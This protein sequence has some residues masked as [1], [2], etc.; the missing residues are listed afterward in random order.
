[1]R[2]HP[3]SVK[4]TFHVLACIALGCSWVQ[5]TAAAV[6]PSG[7]Y[8][9]S[10]AI[11]TPSFHELVPQ[12]SIEYDSNGGNGMLGVGWSLQGLSKI[13]VTSSTGGTPQNDPSDRFRLDGIELIACANAPVGSSIAKSPSC[14]YALPAPLVGYTGR[15]ETFKRIA[16]EPSANGGRWFVWNRDGSKRTYIQSRDMAQWNIADVIDVHGNRVSYGYIHFGIGASPEYLNEVLYNQT[17]IKLHWE[18]RSDVIGFAANSSKAFVDHRLKSI[19]IKVEGK[20][21]RAYAIQYGTSAGTGRSTPVRV[22]TYGTNATVDADGNV[23]GPS[24]PAVTMLYDD[25]LTPLDW[26]S[27]IS[28]AVNLP[29]ATTVGN[30]PNQYRYDYET[31]DTGVDTSF[32][33]GDFDGDGR[34]D[35]LV[36]SVQEDP[37][38]ARLFGTTITP[39]HAKLVT[40]VR[41]ASQ[42]WVTGDVPFDAPAHWGDISSPPHDGRNKLVKAWVADVNGDGLDDLML[43]G[44]NYL[45]ATNPYAGLQFQLNAAISSGDGTFAL[46]QPQFTPMP[47]TSAVVWGPRNAYP[48]DV[49]IC[50]PG[51]FDG[52]GRADFACMFQDSASKHFLGVA[53]A[54]S[55]GSFS[56]GAVQLIADDPGTEVTGP[57]AGRVPFET[58]RMAAGD[59]NN[60][61]QTDLF[62]LDLNPTDVKACAQ[63]GEPTADAGG[64]VPIRLT[65]TIKY[66]LLT[67]TSTGDGFDLQRTPTP[68]T[69]AD[70]LREVPGS[71]A[72][73]DLDGDGRADVMFM[74]GTV[75]SERFQTLKKIRTAIRDVAGSYN[76]SEVDLAPALATTQVSYALGDVNGDGR[77][78]LMIATPITTGAGMGCSSATFQRAVLTAVAAKKDGSLNLPSR[79][80][81]CTVSQEVTNSWAEWTYFSDLVMLQGGDSNGD[82]YA[83]FILPVVRPL[84]PR[85]SGKALVAVYD[86]VAQPANDAPRRWIGADVNGDGKTD[87]ISIAP[88][89]YDSW[90]TTLIAQ[91][92]GRYRVARFQL[93]SNFSTFPGPFQNASMRSWRIMD[94]NAD[95]K[96]DIVHLQCAFPFLKRAC[97]LEL[98]SFLSLGDGT[99]TREAVSHAAAVASADSTALAGLRIGD[100]NG[101][102]RPDLVQTL[103]LTDSANGA[104]SLA[105]RTLFSSGSGWNQQP[106]QPITVSGAA[107]VGFISPMASLLAWHLGDFDGDGRTDL[108]HIISN[109][110][111]ARLTV[112]SFDD[113]SWKSMSTVVRH[114]SVLGGWPSYKGLSNVVRWRVA[115]VNGDGLSDLVRLVHN[116]TTFVVQSLE[117]LG[118]HTWKDSVDTVFLPSGSTAAGFFGA[119]DFLDVDV[120]GDGLSDFAFFDPDASGSLTATV[121]YASGTGFGRIERRSINNASTRFVPRPTQQ[122]GD[123]TGSGSTSLLYVDQVAGSRSAIAIRSVQLGGVDD[124]LVQHGGSGSVTDVTYVAAGQFIDANASQSCGLPLGSV[125]KVVQSTAT[126]DGRIAAKDKTTYGYNCP[127]WSHYHRTL[128]GWEEV[129]AF[130]PKL[131]NR[132]AFAVRSRYQNSDSC[133]AQLGAQGTYDASDRRFVGPRSIIA[134][135]NPGTEPPYRCLTNYLQRVT[136]GSAQYSTAVNVNTS[137]GYDEFGNVVAEIEDGFNG[138]ARSTERTFNYAPDLFIVGALGSVTLRDGPDSSAQILHSRWFCYDGDNTLTCTTPPSKGLLT[139]VIAWSGQGLGTYPITR[140]Q[141]DALGNLVSVMDPNGHGTAYF[142]DPVQ[143]SFPEAVVNALGQTV[144]QVD[145][146]RTLGM[147]TQITGMNGEKTVIEYDEFGRTKR[148]VTPSN[149]TMT[150][151]YNSWGDPKRQYILDTQHDGSQDGLWTRQYLDGLGRVY[152][153]ERKSDKPNEIL[154]QRFLYSDASSLLYRRSL[155]SRWSKSGPFRA[156]AYT[157]YGYDEAGRLLKL[158]HPGGATIKLGIEASANR[159][160]LTLTDEAGRQ[161]QTYHDAFERLVESRAF[162]G[163]QIASTKYNYDG[164]DQIRKVIDP[165]GNVTLYEWDLLGRNTKVTDPD[166]GIR[167]KSYDLAGNLKTIT[168]DVSNRMLTLNYDALNRVTERIY[169]G[170]RVIWNYDEATSQNGRGRLTSF[171]DLTTTGCGTDSG[172]VIHYEPTGQTRMVVRCIQGNRATFSFKYDPLVGRL[173]ETTYP[174]GEVVTYQYDATGLLSHMPGIIEIQRRDASLRPTRIKYGNGVTRRFEYDVDRGWLRRQTDR[175]ANT[176]IFDSTYTYDSSG[177]L[178]TVL[179]RANNLNWAIRYDGLQRVKSLSG[180]Q[181]QT[182]DYDLAGNIM[183][184][185]S[186]GYY[187]Y[188]A[189]GATACTR[190][191]GAPGPCKQPHAAQSAGKFSLRYDD[192]GLLSSMTDTAT[193][194][195]RSIDWTFDMKPSVVLDFDGTQTNF[196]YD[197]FGNRAVETRGQETIVDFGPLAHK[198]SSNGY[199]NTYIADDR[200]IAIKRGGARTWLHHDRSGSVRALTDANGVVV[201]RLNYA[202]FGEA[203]PA[204]GLANYS[205]KSNGVEMDRGTGLQYFGARFFD[206]VLNRFISPD[207]IVPSAWNTQAMNRYAYNYNNPLAYTDPSG[208]QPIDITSPYYAAPVPASGFDFSTHSFGTWSAGTQASFFGVSA[209]PPASPPSINPS[210]SRPATMGDFLALP[211]D[212]QLHLVHEDMNPSPNATVNGSMTYDELLNLEASNT[213][214]MAQA[215]F[216]HVLLAGVV[217]R[218]VPAPRPTSPSTWFSQG[219]QQD[220]KFVAKG[221]W[222][223]IYWE[224]GQ[225]SL[226]NSIYAQY[227]HILDPV[228]R[229]RAIAQDYG[230][231]HGFFRIYPGEILTRL[232]TGPT[233]AARLLYEPVR[234]ATPALMS[235]A[236]KSG[237]ML[238]IESIQQEREK[239]NVMFMCPATAP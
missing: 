29:P 86:R 110:N 10:I 33:V 83:D 121:L 76:L 206:P 159:F 133:F 106:T 96:A 229:G 140:L 15:T 145:W 222:D 42:M 220:S 69:R 137:F 213:M 197:A 161:T 189:Q 125:L 101:D 223:K 187:A 127:S 9:T 32:L 146:D 97:E 94:V 224:I 156:R 109:T 231:L 235:P 41:L 103:V 182:W 104:K 38:V 226:P 21:L 173:T 65:C 18:P 165:N 172:G 35:A 167:V 44:W 192:N 151:S 198:S 144:V 111:D 155:P 26:K 37:A 24:L 19:D 162:D 6:T 115:D 179:S 30:L 217:T 99:F 230:F 186:L 53:H 177:L 193:G 218:P 81:D 234:N 107:G 8:A 36:L 79:W 227:S 20:R 27:A 135:L 16:F 138:L 45:S 134:Y 205:H 132:P 126:T 95:G 98:Q 237:L 60:D 12:L 3:K 52:D 216:D 61:G 70:V 91:S 13:H 100:V 170:S 202:P 154:G 225:K 77:T 40:H 204:T 157:T 88:N 4:N 175:I 90:A 82:G 181:T 239:K 141:Y 55:N 124:L 67:L 143:R 169:P 191:G 208:N 89:G 22:N 84:P 23:S 73:A 238:Y 163:S 102:G 130:K 28:D 17:S 11:E 152:K 178:K 14:K 114:P 85:G 123:V 180:S 221:F 119:Q 214:A 183:F 59:A 203:T 164:A 200:V 75:R 160:L 185:S 58:R 116:D 176:N 184:N 201:G 46:A 139:A 122:F 128:L 25:K 47:W 68:W 188:N 66:D 54:R 113:A 118:A 112:A 147:P 142:L 210:L 39:Q 48:E 92:A 136:H 93:G 129:A 168:T 215:V 209:P 211:W 31:V 108:L 131:V 174:D 117:S 34:T 207:T 236:T 2:F 78:D 57:P 87:F 120:D 195:M 153:V 63:L 148:A 1:M 171:S 5:G 105:V 56:A 232:P 80:D 190:P 64:N 74:T 43:L 150:R 62:V 199:T 72:A 212:Q 196:D 49:P 194:R 149:G 71:L 228:A 7:S 51:D 50:L 158:T 219:A 233:S 166:L